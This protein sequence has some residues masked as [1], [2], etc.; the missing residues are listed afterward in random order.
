MKKKY[1]TLLLS[2]VLLAG[3]FA[4]AAAAAETEQTG[5]PQTSTGYAIP[6]E[7]NAERCTEQEVTQAPTQQQ[8]YQ[9]MIALKK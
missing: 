9:K 3:M 2:A 1:V 5:E 4:P 6:L 7:P 8:A